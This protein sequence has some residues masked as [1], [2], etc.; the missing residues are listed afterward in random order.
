[1]L[2]PAAAVTTEPCVPQCA[3]ETEVMG[4]RAAIALGKRGVHVLTLL[5]T[6]LLTNGVGPGRTSPDGYMII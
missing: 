2:H 5:L 3:S 6:L 4:H 1:V